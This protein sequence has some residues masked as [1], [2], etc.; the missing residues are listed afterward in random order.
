[1][2]EERAC[3]AC[4]LRQHRHGRFGAP[5]CLQLY[6]VRRQESVRAGGVQRHRHHDRVQDGIFRRLFLAHHQCAAVPFCLLF[7][8]PGL[9]RQDVHLFRRLFGGAARHADGAHRK[10]PC[11]VPV[12]CAGRRYHLSRAHRGCGGGIRVRLEF[13]P[14]CLDGRRGRR[15]KV[16]QQEE[17]A[18]QLLLD[19]LRHQRGHRACVLLCV[20]RAGRQRRDALRVQARVPVYALLFPFEH[21]GQQHH[22]GL[23]VGV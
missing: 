11:S 8:R 21:G 5:V 19:Q 4:S 15:C 20:R 12:R 17:S 3:A 1:M 22:Q 2:Y 18:P 13:P 10:R 7:H 14:Q 16:R 6:A 9:R 23:E